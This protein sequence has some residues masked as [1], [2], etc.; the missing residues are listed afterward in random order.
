MP[1]LILEVSN[2]P[3]SPGGV[4]EM[5]GRLLRILAATLL[6]SCILVPFAH[7]APAQ[8]SPVMARERTDAALHLLAAIN[9]IRIG[10]NATIVT[11]QDGPK[12]HPIVI[13]YAQALQT[14]VLDVDD[15]KPSSLA[16]KNGADSPGALPKGFSL[17]QIAACLL[18]LTLVSR[19]ISIARQLVPARR[20]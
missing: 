7:G 9:S 15:G 13:D 11:I 5:L 18:G 2:T 20:S 16:E 6:T 4:L 8:S 12:T 17:A 1:I 10:A 19:V 14:G 3:H